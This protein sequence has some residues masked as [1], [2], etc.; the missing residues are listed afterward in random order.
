MGVFQVGHVGKGTIGSQVDYFCIGR[1]TI[2]ATAI[3]ATAVEIA[4]H[5]KSILGCSFGSRSCVW[6]GVGAQEF[7]LGRWMKGKRIRCYARCISRKDG[8]VWSIKD[9]GGSWL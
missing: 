2:I 6:N 7:F 5:N 3:I 8:N 4:G 9:V 1:L